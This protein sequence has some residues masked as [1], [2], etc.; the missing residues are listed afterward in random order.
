MK[1]LVIGSGGR[2][3]ALAKKLL[4]DPKVEQVFCAKGNPGM[5]RD[6]VVTVDIAEDDHENLI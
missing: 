1:L 3:H 2:E 5:K 4:E 6:G